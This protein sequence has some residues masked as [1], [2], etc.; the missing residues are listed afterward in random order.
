M[1]TSKYKKELRAKVLNYFRRA[2]YST[3]RRTFNGLGQ[4]SKDKIRSLHLQQRKNKLQKEKK[5]IKE[6]K[7]EMLNYLASGNE[8]TP[9]KIDPY[10]V[11]VKSGTKEAKVF[12]FATFNWSIPVSDG[13]GRRMRFLIMDRSNNKLIGIFALGDPVYNL[14][15]R[16]QW[17]GW[18]QK[19]K[20]K[21][22]VNVMDAYILGAL[23]PYSNLIGGKLVAAIVSSK[24]VQKTFEK[25][26]GDSKSIIKRRKIKP[27]LVL[28]TTS[29]ALGKSSIYDRLKLNGELLFNKVGETQGYGHFHIPDRLFKEFREYLRR[30][31]HPYANGFKYGQGANWKFRVIRKVL[32]DIGLSS[33]LLS[34]GI[35]REV[36]M[37]PL[38]KNARNYL[39]GKSKRAFMKTKSVKEISEL[40][41]NRWL[42]PR[43]K[44]DKRYL[45]IKKEETIK[46]MIKLT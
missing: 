9:E 41:K 31:K 3:K 46:N 13:Y 5:F 10:I 6:F 39:C 30:I 37:I 25:K 15:V 24:E 22:L 17:I 40:C 18:D 33:E 1:T 23:P 44:R 38:A 35:K 8:I 29:S 21:Y 28:L 14:R 32:S 45:S 4:V 11:E 16:D 43:S 2:G 26:Y 20:A 7:D 27:K 19:I 36:Y 12:R 34:H 42:I